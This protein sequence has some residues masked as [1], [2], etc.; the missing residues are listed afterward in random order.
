MA[1]QR[2]PRKQVYSGLFNFSQLIHFAASFQNI[3]ENNRMYLMT[4]PLFL[5]ITRQK[6]PSFV[7]RYVFATLTVLF[8][9]LFR[10][11]LNLSLDE[12]VTYIV[13]TFAVVISAWFGGLGAGLFAT[14]LCIISGVFFSIEP[15]SA[16]N[17]K[18]PS[19]QLRV[20]L[21]LVQGGII[22]LLSEMAQDATRWQSI[23]LESISDIFITYDRNMRF[24]Y[25]N[26]KAEQMFQIPRKVLIGKKLTDLYPAATKTV[27]YKNCQDSL[28]KQKRM[29]FEL[30]MPEEDRWYSVSLYPSID[31]ISCY[32]QDI[33][34]RK[35]IEQRLRES[36]TQFRRFVDANVIGVVIE[37]L[38]GHIF[39]ANDIFLQMVG[40]TREDLEKGR[41]NWRKMTPKE[42]EAQ[43]KK[44][45]QEVLKKGMVTPYIKEYMRKDGKRIF[46][47]IGGVLLN[48]STQRVIAFSLDITEQKELE[49]K[50]NEFIS[51]ASHELKTPLTTIKAFT[52]IL[53]KQQRATS[54]KRT[55]HFLE[56]IDTQVNKLNLLIGDL[57]DVSKIEAGKLPLSLK[58]LSISDVVKSVVKDY[59]Y[60][61]QSHTIQVK[62]TCQR[63]TLGDD[64]RL[65]QV[66]INLISNAVKYSPTA[67]TVIVQLTERRR[68]VVVSVKDFG[69]GIP[70]GEQRLVFDRFFRSKQDAVVEIGGFGLGLYISKEIIDRHGGKI[71]VTSKEGKGSTFSFSLPL[72][73]KKTKEQE[74]TTREI[75]AA[76]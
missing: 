70:E 1:R 44:T 25:V 4:Q 69:I 26:H 54:D 13:F 7:N 47:M 58:E 38:Q 5:M 35:R 27:F 2:A 16:I 72:V 12:N 28:K 17:L 74:Q 50:K 68:D 67:K 63:K 3:L 59:Q 19:D 65:E 39:E 23:I 45:A 32:Y 31:G 43:E 49:K 10:S 33:T 48:K 46:I 15:E 75:S 18:N 37:D 66:L 11:F 9:S 64:H 40:Y 41:I 73:R 56:S 8:I 21:F 52:Q 22:S 24:M 34:R 61:T 53:L 51:I 57:L 71:W 6:K 14:I 42:Y 30:H 36:Q 55:L 76:L 62:G 20:M 60:T 29:K